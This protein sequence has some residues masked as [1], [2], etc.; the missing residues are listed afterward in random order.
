MQSGVRDERKRNG[1][2]RLM[3]INLWWVYN[4]WSSLHLQLGVDSVQIDEIIYANVM[5]QAIN[6]KIGVNYLLGQQ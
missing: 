2:L 3:I 1:D 6:H 4:P 5:P